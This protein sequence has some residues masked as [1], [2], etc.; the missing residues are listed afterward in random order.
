MISHDKQK[1][2]FCVIVKKRFVA[3]IAS[4]M[5]LLTILSYSAQASYQFWKYQC[6]DKD[7]ANGIVALSR[8]YYG[9]ELANWMNYFV[10]ESGY[11]PKAFGGSA[12]PARNSGSY[13]S[14]VNDGNYNVSIWSSKGCAAYA[15]FVSKVVYGSDHSTK[16]LESEAHGK[17]TAEGVKNFIMYYAQPGEHIRLGNVH[18]ITFVAPE[19]EGFFYLNYQNDNNPYISLDFATYSNLASICNSVM[20]D[21]YIYNSNTND[22]MPTT[23]PT[24]TPPPAD[25]DNCSTQY[26]GWYVTTDKD[27]LMLR[28]GH[29]GNSADLDEIPRRTVIYISKASGP[30][31]VSGNWGHTNYNGKDGCVAMR[32]VTPT[33]APVQYYTFDLNGFV[34]GVK[35]GHLGTADNEIAGRC[36]VYLN[37]Q[38][39]ADDSNDYCNNS[40][41]AGTTYEIRNIRAMNG[42]T[43]DGVYSGSLSGMIAGNT[44]V[45]LT[46]NK[47][48]E[49]PVI[50][51]V[52]ITQ[53][54]KDGYT[55]QCTVTDNV[56]V[57]RVQFPTWTDADGQ[58]DIQSEWWTNTAA[59]GHRIDGTNTWEYRVNA[60]DHGDS[61]DWYT[62]HI[63]AYDD[64]GNNA[65]NN[66]VRVY[67]DKTPPVIEDVQVKDVTPDGYTVRC[68]V[69]DAG[70]DV[71]KVCFP[72]WTDANGQD[73]LAADWETSDAAKGTAV[74]EGYY[75]F[76]VKVAD[77]NNEH[78]RYWTRIVAWDSFGNKAA[79]EREDTLLSNIVVPE[80]S[81]ASGYCGQDIKWNLDAA[82]ALTITGKGAMRNYGGSKEMPW[83]Q[84]ADKIKSVTLE[85]G[86]T[87]VGSF[88]FNSMPNLEVVNIPASVTKIGDY[89]F[90]NC[91]KLSTLNLSE[92]L[93]SIG[94]SAFYGCSALSSITMPDSLT[95]VGTYVFKGCTGLTNVKLSNSLTRISESL[96]YGCTSL[97]SV[98]IPEGVKYVDGYVFKNCANLADVSLPESLTKLGESAFYGCKKLTTIVI[99]KNV[100]T[101]GSYTFKACTALAN[102][103]LPDNLKAIGES[104]FYGCT[105][106]QKLTIPSKTT[107]I[108]DYAFKNCTGLTAVELPASLTKIGESAFYASKLATLTIPDNV[109][110]IGDYAFKNCVNLADIHLPTSLTKIGESVFYG[111]A[112]LTNITIPEK[113]TSIGSYAFRKCTGLQSVAFPASLQTI[114]E[115][116]FYGCT[117]LKAITL[118]DAVTTI[119][120]YAFKSCT[121][122]DTVELSKNLQNLGDS[123]FYGC[124]RLS[125]VEI[126]AGVTMMGDYLFSQCSNLGTIWFTGNA[127]TI[128]GHAFSKV[129][130]DA[131]YP[132]GNAT[133]TAD[134]MQNY[135]GQIKWYSDT[136]I[137]SVESAPEQET[138][139]P[140]EN[141]E[142]VEAPETAEPE[143]IATPE[144]AEAATLEDS[145]TVNL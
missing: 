143:M 64:A 96:F 107:T 65:S 73:D 127:P 60:S 38:L 116:S 145:D 71:A 27:T 17:V 137:A 90:K 81:I 119:Q 42:Y 129:T 22:G 132:S 33:S 43:Y 109:A 105:A 59:S 126:P 131:Y 112:K 6:T 8:Q 2:V 95:T 57:N 82:G 74:G 91:T 78:G 113:V 48:K 108:N 26:A 86:L 87:N 39:V 32:Y 94:E 88:A 49:P 25:T 117:A 85:D 125:F 135:S 124:T 97:T 111:C 76:K 15:Y 93:K 121:A 3:C 99:P 77:H 92:G 30:Y 133:W 56:G 4:L 89:S 52:K 128:A 28:A 72:T 53:A 29:G 7:W 110:A 40:V 12:F 63:Y 31:G 120:G 37:G 79:T 98:S 41:T 34:D 50:S 115:S 140:V 142:T 55:V 70:K 62:T 75:E 123:A 14:R 66:E 67:V 83:F 58:D 16:V 101:I 46:F 61:E 13:V 141:T 80:E 106:L 54:D 47:E 118:P 51:D 144:T 44:E 10:F 45:V 134:K 5:T 136:E 11:R 139:E 36:D 114:G 100:P 122:L 102:V 35:T 103:T 18:S 23:T 84:Y 104:A 9:D 130:A 20:D 1:E 21:L 138:N 24:P 19:E 68:K 69:T